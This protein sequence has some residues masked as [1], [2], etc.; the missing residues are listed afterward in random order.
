[1]QSKSRKLVSIVLTVAILLIPGCTPALD[2]PV[3]GNSGN[4]NVTPSETS[5]YVPSETTITDTPSPDTEVQ[6]AYNAL[7][8]EFENNIEL[9]K[10]AYGTYK[11]NS[12]PLW[13]DYTDRSRELFEDMLNFRQSLDYFDVSTRF[14][15]GDDGYSALQ[16]DV[17]PVFAVGETNYRIITYHSGWP[18]AK[19]VYIQIFDEKYADAHF[20]ATSY[21]EGGLNEILA[22]CDFYQE[23]GRTYLIVAKAINNVAMMYT[24]PDYRIVNYELDG[25][26]I[27]NYNALN[28]EISDSVWTV[29]EAFYDNEYTPYKAATRIL[30]TDLYTGTLSQDTD[31]QLTFEGNRL[32]ITLDNDA[33]DEISLLFVDGFWEV[34][35]E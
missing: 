18:P 10:Q 5:Q 23:S 13:F 3:V 2:E 32:T 6:D 29:I 8:A 7:K 22:Y 15:Y 20:I 34:V 28:K 25:R 35:E 21:H 1:M 31:G 19:Y 11:D 17:N 12:Y 24:S 27:R 26:E 33:K 30:L 16:I 4:S 9:I 14:P